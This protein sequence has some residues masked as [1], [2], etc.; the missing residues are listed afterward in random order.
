MIPN[1]FNYFGLLGPTGK[2]FGQMIY[3]CS[4]CT[5]ADLPYKIIQFRLEDKEDVNLD[6]II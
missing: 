1:D 4:E 3:Y 6:V 5:L 2:D